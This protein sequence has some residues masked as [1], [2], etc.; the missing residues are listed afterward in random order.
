LIEP[1]L[2]QVY[3]EDNKD[4]T[5]NISRQLRSWSADYKLRTRS[6]KYVGLVTVKGTPLEDDST[7]TLQGLNTATDLIHKNAQ[8]QIGRDIY[9]VTADAT[10]VAGEVDL[11]IT[12]TVTL[13]TETLCDD[14]LNTQ[15]V[16]FMAMR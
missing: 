5:F 15:Q 14:N 11:S 4:G 13:N 3:T 8:F 1:Q 6:L 16:T 12:P 9:M 7:I 2:S 10:A